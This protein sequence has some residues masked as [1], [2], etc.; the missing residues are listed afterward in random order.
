MIYGGLNYKREAEIFANQQKYEKRLAPYEIFK[1]KIESG[2]DKQIIIQSIVE[3]YKLKI[4]KSTAPNALTC[5]SCLER[6]YENHGT[7]I[8]NRALGLVIATWEGEQQ[9]LCANIISGV[10]KCIYTYGDDMN[11]DAFIERVG[12]FSARELAR[13][14]REHRNGSLGFAEEMVVAYNKR[15]SFGLQR[16]MLYKKQKASASAVSDKP[17]VA[18]MQ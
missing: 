2:N 8:L 10:A 7:S 11:D 3:S 6:I 1:G 18:E 12:K 15:T 5:V 16:S 9:S 17:V 14:A 13:T 4:H